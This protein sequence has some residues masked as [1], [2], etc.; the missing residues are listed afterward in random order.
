MYAQWH[1]VD[2]FANCESQACKFSNLPMLTRSTKVLDV[3]QCSHHY[4]VT[5]R[6]DTQQL[7]FG[8]QLQAT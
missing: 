6:D 1:V 7:D 4:I 2:A 3:Q 8:L 5:V